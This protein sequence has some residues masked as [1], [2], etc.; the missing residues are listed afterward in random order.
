M[1]DK[2]KKLVIDA[3]IARASGGETASHP[4]SVHSRDFLLA[5]LKI[6]HTA[7]MSPAIRDEWNTHQSTFASRWRKSMVAR[8]KL[9]LSNVEERPDIRL[10]ITQATV[11]ETQISAMAKDCHLL[12]AA[13]ATDFRI[14]SLDNVARDLFK[15]TLNDSDVKKVMWVNPDTDSAQVLAWL[16]DGAPEKIQFKL[17]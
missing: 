8:R 9:I 1:S 16:E 5:V 12:E 11:T 3:S 13:I 2:S 7:V 14:A 17:V 4:S 15:S 6:C 10:K